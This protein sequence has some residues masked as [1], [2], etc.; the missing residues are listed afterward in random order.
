MHLYDAY[1]EN[2]SEGKTDCLH[3]SHTHN[4]ACKLGIHTHYKQQTRPR[5]PSLQSRLHKSCIFSSKKTSEL[6]TDLWFLLAEV[7]ADIKMI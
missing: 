7:A 1:S 4:M 2:D 6:L 5:F 3:S